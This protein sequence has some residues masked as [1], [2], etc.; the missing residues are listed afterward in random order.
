MTD[1]HALLQTT[2]DEA[3]YSSGVMSYWGE[4]KD[5]NSPEYVTYQVSANSNPDYADDEPASR[6]AYC[7]IKLY[8]LKTLS[9][10]VAGRTQIKQHR[11]AIAAALKD[12]EFSVTWQD[13]I[14]PADTYDCVL[15]EAE[16][17]ETI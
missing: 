2:L 9:G 17:G 16:Y 5:I 7:I 12:A 4:R 1:I 3:L 8:Y 15:L 10:T 14:D 6:N 13:D 11:D